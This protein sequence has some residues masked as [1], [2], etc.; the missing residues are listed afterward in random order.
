MTLKKLVI[1]KFKNPL[2]AIL[3]AI[4]TFITLSL[5]AGQ[6]HSSIDIEEFSTDYIEAK[7]L[8]EILDRTYCF[9][10]CKHLDHE[11]FMLASKTMDAVLDSLNPEDEMV[12]RIRSF[13]I[14]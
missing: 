8:A 12:I 6:L 11:N 4:L 10:K 5:S 7:V 9:E 2:T 1:M 14:R 3:T 13:H